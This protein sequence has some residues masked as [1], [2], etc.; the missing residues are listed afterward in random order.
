MSSLLALLPKKQGGVRTIAICSSFYRILFRLLSPE[1]SAWDS[2]VAFDNEVVDTAAPGRSA[3]VEALVRNLSF[4]LAYWTSHHVLAIFW[5][6]NKFF[7]SIDV[8]QFSNAVSSLKDY[9]GTQGKDVCNEIYQSG[10]LEES[11]EQ[12]LRTALEDWKRTFA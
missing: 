4:E 10:K 2:S 1:L 5:D 6:I 11:T 7:D 9:L 3:L 12:N 8:D